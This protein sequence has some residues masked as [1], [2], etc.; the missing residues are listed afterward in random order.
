MKT[1]PGIILIAALLGGCA[2]PT[3]AKLPPE[4][5][6]YIYYEEKKEVPTRNSLWNNS[7][8]VF[9]DKKAHRVNDLLTVKITE[10]SQASKNAETD[11]S[12]DSSISAGLSSFFGM[13]TGKVSLGAATGNSFTGK[14]KTT[15]SGS[16]DATITAKIV[17]VLPNGNMVVESRKDI[18]VNEEQQVLVL[19]GIV[20]P[21][22]I[23]NDNSIASSS[24]A[25]SQIF[26]TG[27]GIVSGKQ[28]Q[29]WFITMM[30]KVWPF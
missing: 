14:G 15:R 30:D 28:N 21:E 27:D 25:D 29:G 11:A 12:R 1:I 16:L 22:D 20:R 26:Y 9:A 4:P 17:D 18:T 7:N 3:V 5:P 13:G 6:K 23:A 2:T 8:S 10:S 24:V 19:R